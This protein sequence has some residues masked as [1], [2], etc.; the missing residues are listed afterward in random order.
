MWGAM[1]SVALRSMSPHMA[2]EG[3]GIRKV[4]ATGGTGEKSS[5]MVPLMGGQAP[6]VTAT[7]VRDAVS[8]LPALRS[9]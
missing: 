6:W 4:L 7:G 5:L 9:R 8:F 1:P 3:Q 2:L